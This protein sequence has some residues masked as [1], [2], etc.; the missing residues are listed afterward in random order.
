MAEILTRATVLGSWNS[1]DRHR[2]RAAHT[3]TV[4]DDGTRMLE[5]TR[6]DALVAVGRRAAEEALQGPASWLVR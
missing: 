5:W 4:P 3:I 1:A 2:G 6:L